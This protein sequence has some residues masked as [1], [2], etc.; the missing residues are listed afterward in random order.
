MI[1]K[2]M[3]T[4]ATP[5]RLMRL[6]LSLGPEI[7]NQWRVIRPEFDD[8]YYLA[9]NP[10]VVGMDPLVHFLVHG[11]REDRDPTPDFSIAD[12]TLANSDVKETGVNPFFHYL[13]VGRR[14]GRPLEPSAED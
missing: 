9:S 3:R 8:E 5:W 7:S 14:E 10:D 4:L 12:Y 2:I 1:S 6:A 11:W 13:T